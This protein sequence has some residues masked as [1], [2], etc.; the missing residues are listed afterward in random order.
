MTEDIS[1]KVEELRQIAEFLIS[2]PEFSESHDLVSA[3]TH[4]YSA[5]AAVRDHLE[6][7]G[8]KWDTVGDSITNRK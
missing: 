8:C 2:L 7:I 1:S 3:V 6:R 4:I 5:S